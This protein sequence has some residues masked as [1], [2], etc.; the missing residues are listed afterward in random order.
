MK[1]IKYVTPKFRVYSSPGLLKDATMR[2]TEEKRL[3]PDE[4]N[5]VVT[6]YHV[7]FYKE[8]T[9]WWRKILHIGSWVKSDIKYIDFTD[10][11]SWGGINYFSANMGKAFSPKNIKETVSRAGG[12]SKIRQV[13]N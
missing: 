3:T 6:I 13:V 1:N 10:A 2:H 4:L 11:I 8:P 7:E 9:V 12:W 5:T